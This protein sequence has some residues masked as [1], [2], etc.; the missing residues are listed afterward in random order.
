ID[1]THDEHICRIQ[2]DAKSQERD[3]PHEVDSQCCHTLLLPQSLTVSVC[4]KS[5]S[6]QL[7]LGN[8]P[9]RICSSCHRNS[10]N[11]CEK[12]LKKKIREKNN[13]FSCSPPAQTPA[14][15]R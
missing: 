10:S 3:M 9:C 8:L 13:F 7:L 6:P 1:T 12:D 14:S 11:D 2:S 15:Q 5:C 4:F